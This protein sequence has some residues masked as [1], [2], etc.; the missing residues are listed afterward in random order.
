MNIFNDEKAPKKNK[1][2]GYFVSR[3]GIIKFLK[4]TIKATV[5]LHQI[6]PR[7]YTGI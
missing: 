5:I 6:S 2:P 4:N 7:N 1:M 3:F